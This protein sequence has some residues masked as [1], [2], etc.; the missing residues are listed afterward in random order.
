MMQR[1]NFNAVA[2]I[3]QAARNFEPHPFER[4]PTTVKAAPADWGR[5]VRRVGDAALLYVFL[6]LSFSVLFLLCFCFVLIVFGGV[7]ANC[8]VA[9]SRDLLSCL[10]GRLLGRRCWMGGYLRWCGG[11]ALRLRLFDCRVLRLL[12]FAASSADSGLDNCI[13]TPPPSTCTA[14]HPI[15]PQSP[16]PASLDFDSTDWIGFSFVFFWQGINGVYESSFS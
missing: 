16:P 5:Q 6:S 11:Y 14:N 10:V 4:Y 2:R 13:Y 9:S 15:S 12:S 3:R 8:D 1:R 7:G